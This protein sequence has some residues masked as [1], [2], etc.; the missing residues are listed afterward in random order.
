MPTAFT[1]ENIV[2]FPSGRWYH[3]GLDVTDRQL[4]WRCAL[5]HR[6]QD[7]LAAR[8]GTHAGGCPTCAASHPGGAR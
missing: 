4:W 3:D 1:P 2:Q 7:T 5:G 8:T 6:W